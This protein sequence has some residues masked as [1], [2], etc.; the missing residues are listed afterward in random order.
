MSKGRTWA[1]LAYLLSILGWLYVSLF[2]REDELA[3]YH[4]KQSLGLTLAAIGSFA[5]WLLGSYVISW[6]PL[7]GPL[8]AAASFSQ[9]ILIYI[10]LVVA[11]VTGM[12]YALQAKMRPLPIIGK[13]A[14][15]IPV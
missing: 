12:V 13:W 14:E 5:L 2:R 7:V 4:V 10:V 8:L 1:F 9:V 6:V 15:R 3:V 11:W